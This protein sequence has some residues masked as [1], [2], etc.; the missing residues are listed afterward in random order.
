MAARSFDKRKLS[1]ELWKPSRFPVGASLARI[2]NTVLV[3]DDNEI[4]RAALR[5]KLR[6]R[7]FDV[8]T[9]EDCHIGAQQ[10]E[11]H[12]PDIII[13]DL[14]LTESEEEN[15]TVGDGF[16]L[17]QWMNQHFPENKPPVIIFSDASPLR[18]RERTR[19]LG[20]VAFVH[21]SENVER[22]LEEVEKA[23]AARAPA[24]VC[25]F[26]LEVPLKMADDSLRA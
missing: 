13:L 26:G 1:Q 14:S 25:S 15:P 16:E 9:A 3:I 2:M 18:N 19:S 24:P 10:A 5:M 20:A 22:L 4:I 17:M 12:R 11:D 23:L 8:L 7:G 21:K 6:R